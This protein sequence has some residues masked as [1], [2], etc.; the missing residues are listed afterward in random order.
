MKTI[1]V[2]G[3]SGQLGRE[4]VRTLSPFGNIIATGKEDVDMSRPDMIRKFVRKLP[5]L[6]M[7]INAAAYTNVEKAEEEPDLVMRINRD[8]PVVFAEESKRRE[9]PMIHYSTDYVFD[10]SK[11]TPYLETDSTGPLSVYGKS[12]LEGEQAVCAI[13]PEQ[14]ILRLCWVY[15][16]QGKNF[17]Q[18][19]LCLARQ[20]VV[21]KVVSD[22]FGAPTWSRLIA[23]ITAGIVSKI[24]QYKN[25]DSWG[26][27]HLAAAGR[28]TWHEFAT[29]IFRWANRRFALDNE[30]PQA[31]TAAEY[32]SKAARPHSSILSTQKLEKTFALSLPDWREQLRLVQEECSK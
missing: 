23:E 19:M 26:V 3:K 7:I 22:Q 1:L 14:M 18:T 15:G 5:E 10:G 30:M 25:F 12:K 20:G 9:I 11:E 2:T 32:P 8:A 4:L 29:E 28:T 27:Y 24:T 17:F 31:I 13:N 16:T 21:P 6:D